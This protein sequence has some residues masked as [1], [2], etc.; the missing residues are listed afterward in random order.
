MQQFGI[1]RPERLLRRETVSHAL[2]FR[3]AQQR[4]LQRGRELALAEQQ[5]GGLVVEGA[6]DLGAVLQRDAVVQGQ[7][8]V[9]QDSLAA[10]RA[11]VGFRRES[12]QIHG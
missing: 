2:A 11:A 7:E 10:S 12:L 6:D 8:R 1:A 9:G 5:R 3:H 4:L